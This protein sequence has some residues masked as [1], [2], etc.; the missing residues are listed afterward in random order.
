[1]KLLIKILS[2]TRITFPLRFISLYISYQFK[3][4]RIFRILTNDTFGGLILKFQNSFVRQR[5]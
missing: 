3:F 5:F 1:M 2:K 4:R